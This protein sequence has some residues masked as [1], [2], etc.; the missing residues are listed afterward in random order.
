PSRMD[1]PDYA[2]E[3]SERVFLADLELLDSCDILV[4]NLDGRI[5]DEGACV[6]LGYAYARGKKV[7]G[8]KTDVR[9]SEYGI[10]N[11]MIS[12]M[13]KEKVARSTAELIA[14]LQ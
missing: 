9:V 7:Y 12:G 2:S 13:L 1:D 8:I 5:P 11:M 14:M 6:E 4:F 3:A 10:D